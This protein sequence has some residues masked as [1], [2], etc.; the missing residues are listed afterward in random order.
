MEEE[1]AKDKADAPF[2][3][4]IAQDLVNVK[5]EAQKGCKAFIIYVNENYVPADKKL[6]LDDEAL[7]ESNLKRLMTIKFS[8]IFHPDKNRNEE[9]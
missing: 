2:R 6:T 7:K 8:R 3:A 1:A 4:M 5:R 9:R